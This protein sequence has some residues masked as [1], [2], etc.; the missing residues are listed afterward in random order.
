M[1]TRRHQSTAS[2]SSAIALPRLY[3]ITD[4]L[5][6]GGRP[7]VEVVDRVLGGVPS[8]AAL[9]QIR[10]KTLGGRELLALVAKLGEVTRAH[11]CRLVVN[12]RIDVALAGKADGV[13]LPE[14]GIDVA[15]ARQ[16]LGRDRIVAVSTHDEKG[17]REAAEKGADLVVLGP[18]WATPSK[19]AHGPPLGL[20]R[21]ERV[22]AELAHGHT[23]LFALGGVT[24]P[25]R[26]LAARRAGAHGVAGIRAFMAAEDPGAAAA[27]F[28]RAL[29]SGR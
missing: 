29:I 24:S 6:T 18:V 25:D 21:F 23:R 3:V 16:L 28:H 7:L 19:A 22:A 2:S 11:G 13:H 8:G 20:A 5:A 17:A 10:E 26:V 12:G 15:T 14:H 1:P 27:S 9:V 4:R